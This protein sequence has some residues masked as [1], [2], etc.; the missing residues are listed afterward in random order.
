M[1]PFVYSVYAVCQCSHPPLI[2]AGCREKPRPVFLTEVDNLKRKHI[3][4]RCF[5]CCSHH[6]VGQ[7]FFCVIKIHP[8][9]NAILK[10][11]HYICIIVIQQQTEY[12][13]I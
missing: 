1:V 11:T 2:L 8:C 4:G 13:N 12:M 7:T 5:L 6:S 3:T 9:E 10:K